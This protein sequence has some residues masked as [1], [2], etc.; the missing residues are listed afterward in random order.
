MMAA[1][2]TKP[3]RSTSRELRESPMAAPPTPNT[4]CS[5]A[6]ETRSAVRLAMCGR[7]ASM[8][9]PATLLSRK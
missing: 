7:S 4:T 6:T 1:I 5:D 3:K 9:D 8:A 2:P